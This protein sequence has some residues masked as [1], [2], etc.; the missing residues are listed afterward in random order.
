MF[1][2]WIFTIS[3]GTEEA[4]PTK[5]PLQMDSG[6]I[7]GMSVYNPPGAQR[8]CRCNIRE[9]LSVLWPGNKAAYIA[10]DGQEVNWREHYPLKSPGHR[11]ILHA[12]NIDDTYDHDLVV[13]I[14][15]LPSLIAT[16]GLIMRDLVDT[17]KR[18][19]G[20]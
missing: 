2:E 15:V 3:A 1:Y 7:V 14:N 9:E 18:L 16:P 5:E 10:T 17:F 4:D 8:L 19:I 13:R 11:L 12:W 20:V 6:V